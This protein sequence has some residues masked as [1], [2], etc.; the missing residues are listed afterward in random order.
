MYVH[1]SGG[2]VEEDGKISLANLLNK[3]ISMVKIKTP[4]GTYWPL[5]SDIDLSL[6]CWHNFGKLLVDTFLQ[7]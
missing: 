5:K 4:W 6:M 7:E 2:L 3:N 1:I